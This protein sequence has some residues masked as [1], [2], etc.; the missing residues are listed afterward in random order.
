MRT[1][2]DASSGPVPINRFIKRGYLQYEVSL[3]HFIV[4]RINLF[5]KSLVIM[6]KSITELLIEF[7]KVYNPTKVEEVTQIQSHYLGKETVLFLNLKKK[8]DISNYAP[9]DEFVDN[10]LKAKT[11]LYSEVN[12]ING[13]LEQVNDN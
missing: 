11:H 2:N 12:K 6:S 5:I 13:V 4:V 3:P 7:Y 10:S 8:Y 9:F 1:E